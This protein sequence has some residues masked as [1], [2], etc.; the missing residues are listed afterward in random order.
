[1]LA[2]TPSIL[3]DMASIIGALA[4]ICGGL[5]VLVKFPPFR[6]LFRKAV[7]DP[8]SGWVSVVVEA[9]T[10]QMWHLI[11]YHLGSNG[12]TRPIH[13]RISIIEARLGLEVTEQQDPEDEVE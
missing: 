2:A 6:L 10:A 11:H 9:A 7:A 4:V 5:T 1:M 12:T 8:L 3:T 13:E